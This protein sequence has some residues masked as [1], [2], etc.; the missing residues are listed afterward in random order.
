MTSE[1]M[2]ES[3][4]CPDSPGLILKNIRGTVQI[5][6]GEDGMI[7][8][9]ATKHTDSGDAE[10]THIDISQSDDGSVK[11]KTR[12]DENHFR[13]LRKWRPC[14]VDYRV[15]VP[16]NCS[17]KVR[18]VSNTAEVEG[19]TGNLEISSVSGPL[20]CRSL[21][22][23][24]K[25]KTVSGDISGKDISGPVELVAVSGDIQVKNSR[26]SSITGKTVSGDIVIETSIEEGPYDFN[27]VSGDIKLDI[28]SSTGVTVS[29]SS[30]SGRVRTDL[31]HSVSSH[32][33]SHRKVD[34]EGGGIAISHHSV[35]GDLFLF[36]KNAKGANEKS[37]NKDPSEEPFSTRSEILDRI[38]RGELSV[39]EAVQLF[40]RQSPE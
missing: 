25:I 37:A 5:K 12:F 33:R 38:T 34:V 32:P 2:E 3:F 39:D 40:E 10:R 28:P 1:T 30:V 4:T 21:S 15:T 24:I 13:F 17:L 16:Q 19:I 27:A 23:E 26:F 11:V 7:N 8:V 31:P 36:S 29:S 9:I 14:K 20:V 6:P 18:G 22:G 35:S